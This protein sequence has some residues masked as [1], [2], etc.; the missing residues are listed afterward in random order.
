MPTFKSKGAGHPPGGSSGRPRAARVV[1]LVGAAL[2]AAVVGGVLS[3]GDD[4]PASVALAPVARAG[5]GAPGIADPL[6]WSPSRE[7]ELERR[8]ALGV[9]NVIY[10]LAPGGVIASARRTARWRGELESVARRAGVDPDT[11]EA[12]VFLESAGR[13]QVIAGPTPEAAS[14]LGQILPSTA[15]DLLGMRVKLPASIRLSRE[16]ARAVERGRAQ[17]SRRLVRRRAGVDERFQP[18]AA[19]AGAAR[20]LRI[21]AERFGREDLA[22]V[23]YHMGIGNL[24]SVIEA[25]VEP[26][27]TSGPVG[28]IVAR[29]ELS[30]AELYFNSS[31]LRNPNTSAILTGLGDESADYLW[32]VEASRSIMRA[33]RRDPRALAELA[34]LHTAKASAEEVFHP[35]SETEV[36]ADPGEIAE[37]RDEGELALLP[38][39]RRALDFR[40]DPGLGELAGE[41]DQ[42][43]PELYRA[44]RPGALAALV[45]LAARVRS[46]SGAERPLTVTSVVRDL[47]YQEA[48]RAVNPEATQEYSLHTTGWSFD[49]L[50]EYQSD[51]QARAFQFTFDRLRALAVI[52]YAVEPGAIHVTVSER[53]GELIP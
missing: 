36:Y 7:P 41:L 15:T 9:A 5:T 42:A 19:L 21:A 30:Y 37:A 6:A 31:P 16:I 1:A 49:V 34:R 50:R 10:R 51:A 20:Y 40:L 45:Y 3:L 2:V 26:G 27:D 44:L 13:P 53:A 12:V 47:S 33:W 8:A 23:S 43:E 39:D 29:E 11:L 46:I 14:G 28:E 52:D 24:E 17:R 18:R 25:Y 38:D 35:E 32:K 22:V 48:L 4:G